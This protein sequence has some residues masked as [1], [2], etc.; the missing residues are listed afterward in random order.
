M[1]SASSCALSRTRTS[2]A[3]PTR[4]K[5]WRCSSSSSCWPTWR[6][7]KQLERRRKAAKQDHSR[8]AR[9]PPLDKALGILSR[10]DASLPFGPVSRAARA[11]RPFFMLTNKPVLVVVNLGEEA[12]AGGEAEALTK[13]IADEL[14]GVAEVLGVSV[15]LEA[16]AAQLSATD[17]AE[18]MEGLGLGGG[19][20]VWLRR[21]TV[22]SAGAPFSPPGTR[23]A[24]ARTFQVGRQGAEVCRR[25]TFRPSA[26]LCRAE[27]VHW[28]TSCSS[29]GRGQRLRDV[30]KLRVEGKDCE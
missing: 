20:Y 21:P 13:P 6:A 5:T 30:G 19:R 15:K 9:W 12:F 10:Q 17:R 25:H 8:T 4:S 1:P 7:R 26:W 18:M 11:V 16:E 3:A 29:W 28:K 22:C 14:A 24:G 2:L 23:R 27:V